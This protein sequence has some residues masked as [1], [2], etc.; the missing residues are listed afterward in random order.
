MQKDRKYRKLENESMRVSPF[1]VPDGYFEQFPAKMLERIRE[2]EEEAIPV[3]TMGNW[4]KLRVAVAAA[5]LVLALVSYPLIRLLSPDS[6]IYDM[7]DVALIEELGIID[8]DR[9][10]VGFMGTGNET[11]DDQEAF[12]NQ[13]IDYLAVNDVEMD[14]IL[15]E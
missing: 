13:A 4:V 8:D 1:R 7:P 2:L 9:Y 11:L 12:V 5:I 3:R 15:N 6:G 14:I 10:L